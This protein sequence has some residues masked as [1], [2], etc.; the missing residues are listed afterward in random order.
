MSRLGEPTEASD[1]VVGGLSTI[2]RGVF[3]PALHDRPRSMPTTISSASTWR[4]DEHRAS[5]T[6]RSRSKRRCSANISSRRSGASR[7]RSQR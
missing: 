1:E 5:P 6:S 2:E 7:G 3:F 4:L